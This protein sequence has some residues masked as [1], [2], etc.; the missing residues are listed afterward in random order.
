MPT[1]SSL[2]LFLYFATPNTDFFFESASFPMLVAIPLTVSLM[3]M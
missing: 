1:A 3:S 2:S